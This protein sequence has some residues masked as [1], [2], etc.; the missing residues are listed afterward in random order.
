VNA[1][2]LI[3]TIY[4]QTD[5]VIQ[6]L[7]TI[8]NIH[9]VHKTYGAYDIICKI[10]MVPDSDMKEIVEMVHAVGGVHTVLFLQMGGSNRK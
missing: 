2:L 10:S 6:T 9:Q 5:G 3:N 7:S 1:Y 4:G 8:D